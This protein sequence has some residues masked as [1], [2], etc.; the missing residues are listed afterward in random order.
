MHA[1]EI[2]AFLFV[3][4]ALSQRR[5]D[6]AETKPKDA[7][8]SGTHIVALKQCAGWTPN[9]NSNAISKARYTTILGGI[10][11]RLH[12]DAVKTSKTDGCYA[13]SGRKA[14]EPLSEG[15]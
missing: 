8:A 9:H 5:Q 3:R 2:G 7:S 13:E 6:K 1:A 10:L 4:Q 11:R 14:R 12:A 15:V